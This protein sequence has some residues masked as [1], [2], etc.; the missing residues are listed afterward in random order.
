MP[1]APAPACVQALKEASVRYPLRSRVS[2]GICA[3]LQHSQRSPGS[4]HETGDAFDL[5]HDP[6]RGCDAHRLAESLRV[7]RDPRVKY[8]ISLSRIARSY[9]KPGT[10]AWEWAPY[11]GSNLHDKHIH[12]SIRADS[13]GDTSPWWEEADLTAEQA[14][15]LKEVH[16]MLKNLLTP[17]NLNLGDVV[18][19]TAS[20]IADGPE[21]PNLGDVI[22]EIRSPGSSGL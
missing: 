11:A 17:G 3:S 20:R 14:Q 10:P 13:R 9:D 22:N 15:M 21:R 19:I 7:R 2:D 5:T 16:A 18:N 4:D 12:V 1:C 8:I 6:L